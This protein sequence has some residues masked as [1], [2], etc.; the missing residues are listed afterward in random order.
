MADWMTFRTPAPTQ[1]PYRSWLESVG[2]ADVWP[3]TYSQS[4]VR[5]PVDCLHVQMDLFRFGP[6]SESLRVTLL[7]PKRYE[8]GLE[9]CRI[10]FCH[11]QIA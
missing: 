10:Q 1:A 7:S 2:I 9:T 3:S 5:F 11:Y 8:F 6:A 4:M